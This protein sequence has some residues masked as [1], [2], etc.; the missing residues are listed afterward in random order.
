MYILCSDPIPTTI[1]T[2]YFLLCMFTHHGSR[3][4][5]QLSDGLIF[6][7]LFQANEK[8]STFDLALICRPTRVLFAIR[9]WTCSRIA[10]RYYGLTKSASENCSFQTIQSIFGHCLY[11]AGEKCGATKF[12]REVLL[13]FPSRSSKFWI[14]LHLA[15]V[16]TKHHSQA[17]A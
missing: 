6:G 11:E 12:G 2:L 9:R 17:I 14:L 5:D 16:I 1:T 15:V 13:S 3:V 4:S 8:F 7:R 10:S